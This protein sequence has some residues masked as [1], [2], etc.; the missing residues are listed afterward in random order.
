MDKPITSSRAI[1]LTAGQL[2]IESSTNVETIRYFERIGLISRADR[3]IN[4]H[5]R[6]DGS[7]VRQLNFIRR[8]REMGFSQDEV[9]SLLSLSTT[10]R[11]SCSDVKSIANTNLKIIRQKIAGL[12]SL[13]KLLAEVS[14]RCGTGKTPHCPVLEALQ[15][16]Q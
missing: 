6:F 15:E 10:G 14:S 4:G 2:A 8:S 12:R 13:E 5:R 11:Q 9:R 7:H 3:T 16:Q 1:A